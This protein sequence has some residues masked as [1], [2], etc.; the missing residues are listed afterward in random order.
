MEKQRNPVRRSEAKILVVDDR[1]DN[2]ISIEA[3]LKKIIIQLSKQIPEELL[4]K[5]Y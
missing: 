5:Y 3:F 1:A 4:L 2:L